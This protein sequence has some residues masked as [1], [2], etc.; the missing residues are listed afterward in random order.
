MLTDRMYDALKGEIEYV[1]DKLVT[2]IRAKEMVK[3]YLLKTGR[4]NIST[5]E[6]LCGFS[7]KQVRAALQKMREEGKIMLVS[8][9]RYSY[10]VLK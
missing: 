5:V 7:E 8:K 10:Y 3:E 4:I 2:Y 9:G 1:R 6:E